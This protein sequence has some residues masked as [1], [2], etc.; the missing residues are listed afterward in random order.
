MLAQECG[1]V[2]H[3]FLKSAKSVNNFK[4]KFK[5]LFSNRLSEKQNDLDVYF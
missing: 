5:D 2:C 1:I 3:I 4:N